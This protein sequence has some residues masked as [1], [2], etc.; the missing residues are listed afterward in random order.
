MSLD[1]LIV[2]LGDRYRYEIVQCFAIAAM[3]LSANNQMIYKYQLSCFL[4]SFCKPAE[5]DEMIF[6]R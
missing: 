6:A 4:S 1:G 2:A 5:C 3:N